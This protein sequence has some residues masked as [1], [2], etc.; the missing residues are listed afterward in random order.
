MI[1]I[2][3]VDDEADLLD[4]GKIFLEEG[5]DMVVDT[6][7][8][9]KKAMELLHT[10]V[11]DAVVSDFQMPDMDGIA[12]LQYI[13][14]SNGGLPV[15]LFTGKGKEEV[16]I[17]ALNNG[18][19]YYLQKGGEAELQFAELRHK[20][21]L[22]V[23]RQ[24]A[25]NRILY[26]NRLY[27][28]MSGINTAILHL[29]S[30]ENLF[31][32]ICRITVEEGNFSRAWIGLLN[33]D[34]TTIFP[35]ASYGFEDVCLTGVPVLARVGS[36]EYGLSGHAAFGKKKIVVNRIGEDD[37][38]GEQ[39]PPAMEYRATAAFPIWLHKE[40]IGTFQVYAREPGFFGEDETRLLEE[41]VSDISFA[42]ENLEAEEQRM[43]AEHALQESEEKFRIL[44]EESLV[45]VYIIQGNRFLHVNPKFAEIMGYSREEIVTGLTLDDL[46]APESRSFVAS[47][48]QRRLE[49]DT[50]SLHYAFVGKKK[51]GTFIDLEVAGTRAVLQ[52][53]PIIIG[54]IIDITD[55]K[56]AEMERAEKLE[57]L[58]AAYKKIRSAEERL[59]AHIA[60]LTESQ[61][62]LNES[63]RRMT[64]IINF[65]PDATFAIDTEGHVLVWNRAVE[66]MTGIPAS[67]MIGKGDFEYALPFHKKRQPVLA[68][69]VL[70]YDDNIAR[71]YDY[72]QKDGDK[73]TAKIFLPGLR[74]G[75]GAFAWLV[76][77]PL[78][79][80]RGTIAGV[81]ETIRD[82]SEFEEVRQALLAS[83]ERYRHIIENTRDG[84]IIVQAGNIVFTNLQIRKTL[85]DY[86]AEDLQEKPVAEVI[87]EHE[88]AAVP[89]N[90]ASS[91]AGTPWYEKARVT[92]YGKDGST[93]PLECRTMDID[94]EGKPAT[95]YFLSEVPARISAG[96]TTVPPGTQG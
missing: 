76:A 10:R 28:V 47:S 73:F 60:A 80:T 63:E 6:A 93:C 26:F 34:A 19:D 9:A 13:R 61:D 20:I 31:S 55:R 72:I 75:K 2:L 69:L 12:F 68:N 95:L 5:G 50:T 49:G 57:E 43:T 79:D 88:P 11:Y 27:A 78:Y 91:Q 66:M 41:V 62:R 48:I 36:G 8:S 59:W 64:D 54:T 35:V 17:A 85:G 37:A 96:E 52:G 67:D 40:V 14:A 21:L 46:T 44:V 81:I 71:S 42:L 90:G 53:L 89:A 51:D 45:G 23:D 92:G 1:S 84:V 18:A 3:Y 65:L 39:E 15:I 70:H 82:V 32:E 86:T 83:K 56:R 7:P 16:V 22:A 94:W 38:P 24:K 30:R 87:G 77:A 4:L 29:R 58:S 25:K 74:G 33:P